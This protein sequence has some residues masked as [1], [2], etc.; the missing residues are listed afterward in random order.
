MVKMMGSKNILFSL[1]LVAMQLLPN[2]NG[3]I[4]SVKPKYKFSE[5]ITVDFNN[6]ETPLDTN[7]IAIYRMNGDLAFWS[8][9]CGSQLSFNDPSQCTPKASGSITFSPNDPSH[10]D[11]Y[12]W[13]PPPQKY[14]ACL[15]DESNGPDEPREIGCKNFVV[16]KVPKW[17]KCATAITPEKYTYTQAEEIKAIFVKPYLSY[18]S[19]AGIYP[20]SGANPKSK[21]LKG[22]PLLY[23][24][25]GCNN[26]GGGDQSENNDCSV[27]KLGGTVDF[28]TDEDPL[29][30]GD[31]R[32]C[33]T[34][35]NNSSSKGFYTDYKCSRPFTVTV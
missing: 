33:I 10:D 27:A 23:V 14:R 2:V 8:D 32:V 25:T 21:F 3:Q 24:Y 31:Y 11:V 7:F 15:V 29:D 5:F 17:Y 20:K 19:W 30:P 9:T 6:P 16:K 4:I 22:E 1:G 12:Q 34:Y 13:P 18:N 26:D 28:A 35:S